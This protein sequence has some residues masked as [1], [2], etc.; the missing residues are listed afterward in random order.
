MAA[1]V[2][3]LASD[4]PAH[5]E[6]VAEPAL[7]FSAH[8]P[9]ALSSRLERLLNDP[10]FYKS[11]ITKQDVMW[12]KFQAQDVG[13]RFWEPILEKLKERTAQS[14]QQHRIVTRNSR[15]RITLVSPLPPTQS[16]VAD[17]TA[18]IAHELAKLVELTSLTE[19]PKPTPIP[20]VQ[21]KD[22]TIALSHIDPDQERVISVV[23]NQGCYIKTYKAL[24][25]FGG[26][27]IA[28]D[29]RML[30]FYSSFISESE[31][32]TFASQEL[33]REIN[34]SEMQ[35][36]HASEAHLEALFLNEFLERSTPLIVHS[37][38]TAKLLAERCANE[39]TVL[40]FC[41]YRS[42]PDQSLKPQGR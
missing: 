19:S 7:R 42:V 28:H 23:G 36:W 34:K 31:A 10:E 6:L 5:R 30:G 35:R 13:L 40:P 14:A 38:I 9:K 18:A 33:G 20:G 21:I 3:C 12:P 24:M 41:I 22:A 1:G 25:R 39:P 37:P 16:G 27:C 17:Y 4:I 2:P 32:C 29:A 8:D 26:S 11:V 15:P